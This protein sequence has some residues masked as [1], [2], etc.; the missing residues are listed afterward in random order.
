MGEGGEGGEK[1]RE[2][3]KEFLLEG[4]EVAGGNF[5]SLLMSLLILEV[6]CSF[7]VFVFLFLSLFLV[8]VVVV[9]IL[10]VGFGVLL[11][12]FL[13]LLV[14]FLFLFC[15]SLS[16]EENVAGWEMTG[17]EKKEGKK[18]SRW[19]KRKKKVNSHNQKSGVEEKK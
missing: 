3:K 2:R 9:W 15:H 6:L 13:F 1:E 11:L 8:V 7:F 19:R 14:L 10:R 17:D 18:K 4:G 12:L 16:C 5:W